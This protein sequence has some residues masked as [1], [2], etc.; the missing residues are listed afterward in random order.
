MDRQGN[1]TGAQEA[2]ALCAL[3]P[4]HPELKGQHEVALCF[5]IWRQIQITQAVLA[6]PVAE[7]PRLRSI[8][9]LAGQSLVTP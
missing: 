2:T 5:S 3:I 4:S 8:G 7:S 9:F 1:S 6:V